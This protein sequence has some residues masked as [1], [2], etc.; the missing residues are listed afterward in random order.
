LY[1]FLA[2]SR[3]GCWYLL[4]QK[5]PSVSLCKQSHDH[6]PTSCNL[7]QCSIAVGVSLDIFLKETQFL[8]QI[9]VMFQSIR[10]DCY[11]YSSIFETDVLTTLKGLMLYTLPSCMYMC[12]GFFPVYIR[13]VLLWFYFRHF[14]HFS[15]QGSSYINII[16]VYISREKVYIHILIYRNTK[17]IQ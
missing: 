3:S 2:C 12:S 4:Q 14:C 10:S 17:R 1:L 5:K 8:P 6:I 15:V 13:N 9:A 7:I 16:L 11:F